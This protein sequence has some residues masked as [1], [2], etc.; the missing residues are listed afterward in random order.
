MQNGNKL[1]QKFEQ[2]Y[3]TFQCKLLQLM[4]QID[5]THLIDE[6]LGIPEK[7]REDNVENTVQ[8][9]QIICIIL[10]ALDF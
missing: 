3:E 2:Q 1:L 5:V 6:M 7:E 10:A 8:C 9:I 4:L